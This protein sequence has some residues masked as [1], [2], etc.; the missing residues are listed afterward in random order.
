MKGVAG[1]LHRTNIALSWNL[2]TLYFYHILSISVKIWQSDCKNYKGAV[3][4]RT[5]CSQER[6]TAKPNVSPPGCATCRLCPATKIG[7]VGS[8]RS[9]I[10]KLISDWSW[11]AIPALKIWQ[12]PVWYSG[13][14]RVFP[15]GGG[16]GAELRSAC[17]LSFK[18]LSMY[19]K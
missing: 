18:L 11:T 4:I 5:Q 15:Y 19:C 2:M 17:N 9:G 8:V 13:G 1:N 3:F 7:C 12:R 14:S 6:Y 16:S 10:K